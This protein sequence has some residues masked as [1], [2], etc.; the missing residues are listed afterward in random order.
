MKPISTQVILPD[1][2]VCFLP[3]TGSSDNRTVSLQ[4]CRGEFEP[5]SF[6]L[7]SD[8]NISSINIVP[9]DLSSTDGAVIP[10]TAIDL[11]L[12]KCW[13]QA[14]RKV[15]ETR[16]RIL[17]PELLLKDDD[18]V[19]VDLI[20]KRNSLRVNQ[21]G[22]TTYID[23]SSSDA[24]FP[25]NA[26]I[27]DTKVLQSF[28]IEAN[29]NKQVWITFHIPPD[30]QSGTYNGTLSIFSG[31]QPLANV[32]IR[33]SVLPFDLGEPILSYCLY[34]RGRLSRDNINTLASDDKSNAQYAIELQD[35]K[36]HGI[37]YPTLRQGFD[38]M[39]HEALSIRNA[40]GLPSDKL[41]S[42]GVTTHDV[43]DSSKLEALSIR[44]A[45]WNAFI[46][47]YG[48][49]DLYIYGKDEAE[50]EALLAQ[51][52]AWQ[53]THIANAKV[54]AACYQG[55]SEIVGDI[56][57][58]PILA[59]SFKPTEVQ[60]WHTFGKK[61]FIYANPQV[62]VEDAEL[63]RRNYGIQLLCNSY[64]GAMNYA[65]QHSFGHIWNDFDNERLRDH[66]FAYPTSDGIIDTIQWE[67]FREA[68]DDVR[69][70]TTLAKYSDISVY[71][72]TCNA[73]PKDNDL[74]STRAHIIDR[75][76]S[77]SQTR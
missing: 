75:I 1:T 41:F 37:L 33:L 17:V 68:V 22:K 6:V 60:K 77:F 55:A 72:S 45:T 24:I 30:A 5:A 16:N 4:A 39:L 11:R 73:L 28:S 23:I 65:Y 48:Y 3:L 71:E 61:V 35:M 32:N 47:Q 25:A 27:Y 13:Y 44:I 46:F 59:G 20:S 29:T 56:L 36:D 2:P 63:Y 54:F 76:I 38:E 50:G 74:Y 8:T 70:L 21:E 51:R 7:R 43:I 31:V 19:R 62:G 69:Y 49:R 18:L 52:P 15:W 42:L 58:L 64:D 66:V 12:V 40:V 67:G 10:K 34:Y 26:A 57:D 9:S 14:G 53:A